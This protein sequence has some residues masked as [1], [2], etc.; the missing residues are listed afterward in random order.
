VEEKNMQDEVKRSSQPPLIAVLGCTGTV[1]S[2][3]MRL[4][5]QRHCAVRGILRDPNRPYP[6]PPQDRIARVSYVT[7]NHRSVEELSRALLGTKAL[8]LSTGT[9]LDQVRIELN[10]IE[11][12]Q[13]AGVSRV[14]KLSAPVIA[15]P[16]SVEVAQWHR[17]IENKLAASSMEYCFLRP[18]AFMQNWL[19]NTYTI[20]NFG[21]IIG[22]AGSAPRNYVDCRDVASIATRL[23]LQEQPLNT[24]AITIAGPEV[25]TNQEMANRLARATGHRVQYEN[26]SHGDHQHLLIIRAKLPAWLASHIVELE[27][28]AIQVP[29]RPSTTIRETL[30]RSP[31]TIDEFI[32]EHRAAFTPHRAAWVLPLFLRPR[33]VRA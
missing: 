11:A 22:S 6:V 13:S 12:A 27:E 25:I 5:A 3:V 26:L 28:L 18:Y 19:R 10:A 29:E 32:Q 9:S 20:L 30:G 4:L 8:F 1:G 7:A 21:K 31:R 33:I 15:A 14:I 23:L 24:S 16:A 2:E 17:T